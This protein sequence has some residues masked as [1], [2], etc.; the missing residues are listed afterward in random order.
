MGGAF[1]ATFLGTV[2][3]GWVGSF[4]DQMSLP[5]SGRWTRPS[6]L[7]AAPLVSVLARSADRAWQLDA[8]R[9]AETMTRVRT[10]TVADAAPDSRRRAPTTIAP[11]SDI[12]AVSVIS[13]SRKR[14]SDFPITA[15]RRCWCSI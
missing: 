4:Y 13:H 8:H 9:D 5:P 2:I 1:I 12:R 11:F 6:L 15:C 3:M 10:M 14:G 7:P